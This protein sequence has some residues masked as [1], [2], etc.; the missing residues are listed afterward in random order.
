LVDPADGELRATF[1]ADTVHI[2]DAGYAAITPI[3]QAALLPV[4]Q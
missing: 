2:N 3:A 4:Q 1:A